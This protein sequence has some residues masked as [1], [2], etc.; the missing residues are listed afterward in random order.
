M[1]PKMDKHH[2]LPD[3]PNNPD[4]KAERIERLTGGTIKLTAA[5][6]KVLNLVSCA[7]S[8]KEIA[9]VL[10]ISP[11]TVKRHLKNI[12]RKA[13]LR[14]RVEAAIYGL[15]VTGWPR[16]F[17]ENSLAKDVAEHEM[18][19]TRMCHLTNGRIA[20]VCASNDRKSTRRT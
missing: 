10:K 9:A 4:E 20:R 18:G 7:M 3:L 12:F 14:N 11:A 8:N 1:R 15:Y 5:E 6:T 16:A 2:T 19:F 13:C 17:S